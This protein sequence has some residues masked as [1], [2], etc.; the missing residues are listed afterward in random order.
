MSLSKKLNILML[1]NGLTP[2]VLADNL[3]INRSTI[4]RILSETTGTPKT[5]TIKTLAKYFNVDISFLLDDDVE[6]YKQLQAK[7]ISDILKELMQLTGV[8]AVTL[9]N[10]TGVSDS[11]ISDILSGKVTDPT[12][13]NLQP[14][15]NFFNIT[16]AQLKGL[17]PII[18][19]QADLQYSFSTIPLISFEN[20]EEWLKD[21]FDPESYIK[22]KRKF[23]H[24]KAYAIKIENNKFSPDFL[25]NE[26][27][28]IDP[29]GLLKIS[30]AYI[31][32]LDKI[33]IFELIEINKINIKLRDISSSEIILTDKDSIKNLGL[34]IQKIFKS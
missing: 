6:H 5:E 28:V 4:S 26:I 30:G 25:E 14:I 16:I 10:H 17:V 23:A 22:V 12:I 21:N 3:N 18:N 34:I 7:T 13:K 2:S 31:M 27:L 1:E 24:N 15:A 29:S 11:V 19:Y 33:S 20:I 32:K 9:Q 8:N